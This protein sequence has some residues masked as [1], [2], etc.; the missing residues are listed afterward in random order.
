ME[1][2]KP[3]LLTTFLYFATSSTCSGL[4]ENC[5]LR[6]KKSN[7]SDI[8]KWSN[9]LFKTKDAT[10]KSRHWN[11]KVIPKTLKRLREFFYKMSA[12]PFSNHCNIIKN[13]GGDKWMG[14]CGFPDGEKFVCM[15]KLY[16][17]IQ[18]HKCL[19]YSFGIGQV[20]H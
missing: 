15:D 10:L 5:D 17:D 16:Q 2:M 14:G 12:Q 4:Q 3:F 20:S 18:D 7:Y 8:A 6:P 1:K 11:S 9:E 13:I 19:V